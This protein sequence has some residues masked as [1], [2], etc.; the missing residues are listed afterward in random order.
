MNNLILTIDDGP[1][2]ATLEIASFLKEKNIPAVFFCLG[3]Q[4]EKH[5]DVAVEVC[6]MG[7]DLQNHSYS[8]PQFSLLSKKEIEEEITKTEVLLE[9]TY[10]KAGVKRE[11]KLFRYPYGE[12]SLLF[13]PDKIMDLDIA[14]WHIDIEDYKSPERRTELLG[15]IEFDIHDRIILMHDW[16]RRPLVG[17]VKVIDYLLQKQFNFIK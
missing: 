10:E 8:H 17:F 1:T 16:E 6:K 11:R 3:C 9:S 15:K 14:K 4:I 5:P 13:P 7:F 12:I 2:N